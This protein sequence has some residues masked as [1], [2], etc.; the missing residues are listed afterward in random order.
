GRADGRGI[1]AL[2]GLFNFVDSR[3]L[4]ALVVARNLISVI[5]EELLGAIG[6]IVGFV[7]RLDFFALLLVILRVRFGIFAH[8]LD[9]V[10]GEST[11][12]GNRD[13]LLFAGAK[14]LG[15]DMQ[16]AVRIN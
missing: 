6:S 4:L 14:V 7:A 1:T 10:L 15:A 5:F 8:L 11:A 3:F 16:N 13:F 2:N 9:L 12:S